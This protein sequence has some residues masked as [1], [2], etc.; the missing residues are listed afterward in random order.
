MIVL[1]SALLTYRA[2]YLLYKFLAE[3]K[4]Q[5]VPASQ[6]LQ[7][8]IMEHPAQQNL[9]YTIAL[10]QYQGRLC[11]FSR[12]YCSLVKIESVC[13]DYYFNVLIQLLYFLKKSS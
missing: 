4:H 8:K 11:D 7:L 3:V 6:V 13:V 5:R 9:N 10:H 2:L 1:P 12:T